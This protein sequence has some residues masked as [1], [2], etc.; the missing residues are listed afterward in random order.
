MLKCCP[1]AGAK[2][3]MPGAMVSFLSFLQLIKK[4]MNKKNEALKTSF[5]GDD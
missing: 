4:N 3:L 1:V 5:I 2:Q